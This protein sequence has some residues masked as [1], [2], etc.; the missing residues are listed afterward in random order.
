MKKTFRA[1]LAVTILSILVMPSAFAQFNVNW[2]TS[3]DDGNFGYQDLGT[4]FK[5]NGYAPDQASGENFA[6]TGYIGFNGG[7]ADPYY[8]GPTTSATL[9]VVQ[10]IAGNADLTTLG[11]YTGSGAGKTLT[12]VLGLNQNGPATVNNLSNPFGL[13]FSSPDNYR[14]STYNTWY[15]NR[16]ENSQAGVPNNAGGDPQA[17][18]YSLGKGQWLIAW[19]DMDVTTGLSDRD[20]NDAYVKLTTTVNPEPVS[21]LLFALG[22]LVLAAGIFMQQRKAVAVR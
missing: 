10:R 13:Y 20:Y 21:S 12:Q 3:Q 11:Y 22:G 8:F 6:K 17:L 19:D 4:W 18:I 1:I 7:D 15:T 9:Q 16:A 14:S 5:N 2:G